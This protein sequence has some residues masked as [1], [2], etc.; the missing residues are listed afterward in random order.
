MHEFLYVLGDNVLCRIVREEST[1]GIILPEES[2][3]SVGKSYLV[4]EDT[5]P[6]VTDVIKGDKLMISQFGEKYFVDKDR[7]II[8]YK[9]I[10]AVRRETSL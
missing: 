3:E 5:G 1:A 8:P 9:E 10:L 7:V 6:L 4:V 2:K